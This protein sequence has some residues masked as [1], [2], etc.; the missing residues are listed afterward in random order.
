MEGVPPAV[1]VA[2]KAGGGDGSVMGNSG[3]PFQ[4]ANHDLFSR[5]VGILST[6]PAAAITASDTH[7][8]DTH[9]SVANIQLDCGTGVGAWSGEQ[10]GHNEV[11]ID[12]LEAQLVTGIAL[13]GRNP[14][15]AAHQGH[16]QWPTQVAVQT[17]RDGVTWHPE[18][19]FVGA[20]DATTVVKR[21]LQCPLLASFVKV[22]IVAF[23]THPSMR[24]DILVAK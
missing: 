1:V 9:H 5:S 18:G 16:S 11:T 13:Q 8:E 2:Q 20:F 4:V 3:L 24:M 10:G 21:P 22:K 12:L 7:H 14:S 6:L 23:H 19:S 17:S 15:A